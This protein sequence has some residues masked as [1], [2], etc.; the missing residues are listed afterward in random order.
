[1]YGDPSA[2]Y[3]SLWVRLRRLSMARRLLSANRTAVFNWPAR[4][5]LFAA[6]EAEKCRCYKGDIAR[7]IR[8]A[9]ATTRSVCSV[10]VVL[11]L[12][13]VAQRNSKITP[14]LS[15]MGYIRQ[16]IASVKR[17]C[18]NKLVNFSLPLQTLRCIMTS[19]IEPDH[20]HQPSGGRGGL[21]VRPLASHPCEPDSIPNG[22]A[23]GFSL[24]GNV[25]DDAMVGG[26]PRGFPVLPAFALRRCSKLTWLHP[27]RL[28]K[29]ILNVSRLAIADWRRYVRWS[30]DSQ[31]EDMRQHKLSND[32]IIGSL[33][34]VPYGCRQHYENTVRKFRAVMAH[35][36]D[37]ALVARASV[38]LIA[39][40]F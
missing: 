37:D 2:A 8:C 22:V 9:I 36:G 13:K 38:T 18:E 15:D 20:Q 25:P 14:Y 3:D 7:S 23:P 39:P 6:S 31:S 40:R 4:L 12:S 35:N 16:V 27:H 34:K 17:P 26:F 11:R 29:T 1:M 24:V 32:K 28:H 19:Q 5:D 10:P 33:L 21:V 30:G